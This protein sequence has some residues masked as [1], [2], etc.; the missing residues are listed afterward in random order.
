ME[1]VRLRQLGAMGPTVEST[2]RSSRT[3]S[4][5]RQRTGLLRA[6]SPLPRRNFH[7]N[8]IDGIP[9]VTWRSPCTAG[10]GTLTHGFASPRR[11]GFAVVE[12]HEL[13]TVNSLHNT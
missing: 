9:S 3:S 11:R 2:K 10:G 12:N 8:F 4:A 6:E 13:M 5:G 7:G 1:K